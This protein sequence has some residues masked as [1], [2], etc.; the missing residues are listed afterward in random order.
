ML[1]RSLSLASD[2]LPDSPGTQSEAS[3]DADLST[4]PPKSKSASQPKRGRHP[5]A[6]PRPRK[7]RKSTDLTYAMAQVEAMQR[8]R[9]R[10]QLDSLSQDCLASLALYL[11]QVHAT[12][13]P[14]DA[15]TT[16]YIGCFGGDSAMELDTCTNV[17]IELIVDAHI[18]E[19]ALQAEAQR[20]QQEL[21]EEIDRQ[22]AQ[23]QP[24][25]E[26]RPN[27]RSTEP[28]PWEPWSW[29]AM[30]T[31]SSSSSYDFSGQYSTTN[32]LSQGTSFQSFNQQD[33]LMTGAA[34]TQWTQRTQETSYT[35]I[36]DHYGG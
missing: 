30:P 29:Y 35:T 28:A 18:A 10:D 22:R 36:V 17:P 25:T 2:L 1:F 23:S 33:S 13:V 26:E 27:V 7:R 4:K 9:R 11:P 16:R 8:R 6:R 15:F 20:S 12:E 21:E 24:S 31:S 34:Q 32:V 14:Q 5:H 3:S 19:F